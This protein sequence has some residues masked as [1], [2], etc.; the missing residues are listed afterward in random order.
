M[1]NELFLE[2]CR[3][4]QFLLDRFEVLIKQS[5]KF[6]K[7]VEKLNKKIEFSE[8]VKKISIIL[9]S[10]VFKAEKDSLD[11]PE[12]YKEFE[13]AFSNYSLDEKISEELKSLEEQEL[14]LDTYLGILRKRLESSQEI[15]FSYISRASE[16]NIKFSF[17]RNN[18]IAVRI[19]IL[20]YS[21]YFNLKSHRNVIEVEDCELDETFMKHYLL[22]SE[23]TYNWF[24]TEATKYKI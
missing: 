13:K 5:D 15:L 12:N 14:S 7:R 21:S 22:P 2:E 10:D 17:R 11:L 4:Y 24:N 8:E 18:E 20:Y 6:N 23:N 19:F 9:N 16:D 3:T 1:L